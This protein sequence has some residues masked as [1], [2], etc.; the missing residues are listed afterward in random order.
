ML[1][2]T[3][4]TCDRAADNSHLNFQFNWKAYVIRNKTGIVKICIE[5]IQH[6]KYL[7]AVSQ[8]VKVVDNTGKILCFHN[9]LKA[10]TSSEEGEW[11]S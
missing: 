1:W 3:K 6:I 5:Y 11:R 8:Q 10:V 4:L 2:V 9:V 7:S